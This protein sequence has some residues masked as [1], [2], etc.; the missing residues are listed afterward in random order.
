MKDDSSRHSPVAEKGDL[1][2]V[3]RES[4][5]AGFLGIAGAGLRYLNALILTR[6]L[7]AA[8]YGLFALANTIL[9]VVSMPASMGLQTSTVHFVAAHAGRKQWGRLRWVIRASFW[10]VLCSSLAWTLLVLFSAPWSSKVLF[11]KEKLVLPLAGLALSLPLLGL[12]N[13]CAGSLQ[14]LRKIRAKVILDRVG[15]PLVFSVF[16]VAGWFF[17]RTMEFVLACFLVSTLL[18]LIWGAVSLAR[19]MKS[20]PVADDPVVP[21][22]RDLLVFSTPVM[23]LNLLNFL[24][25]WS[26]VLV[27]GVYRSAA[28]VGIYHIASRLAVVV[29]I[30]L[31][32]LNSSLAPNFSALHSRGEMEGLKRIYH[33]STRWIFLLS[34][35]VFLLLVFGG[36]P[37]LWAFGRDF[38]A[39]FLAMG[40]LAV[41]QL[42]SSSMGANGTLITQTGYPV[43]NLI[44]VLF[45]GIVNLGLTFLLVPRYGA[46]GAASAAAISLAL[47]N[48]ARSIEIWCIFKISPWDRTFFKPLSGFALAFISGC[49][50]WWLAGPAAALVAG[51]PTFVLFWWLSGPE[52]EDLDLLRKARAKIS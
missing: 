30:P 32:A 31:E 51:P 1:A 16:L 42:I 2:F 50:A 23:S 26:D 21:F 52:A 35:G 3:A 14:G 11:E 7:G 4:G 36:R 40:L 17:F 38:Q 28:E 37:V 47:V 29:N 33:T 20:V 46:T 9:T 43:V 8:A 18:V 10:L 41:G 15:Q 39:G 49:C 6:L 19:S 48:I 13:V 27:M 45:L 25:L 44:N 12:T 22:W 5:Y 24:V 34:A